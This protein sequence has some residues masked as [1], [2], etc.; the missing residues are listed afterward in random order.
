MIASNGWSSATP[1]LTGEL[2]RDALRTCMQSLKEGLPAKGVE[3]TLVLLPPVVQ[4]R[5]VNL[6]RMQDDELSRVLAR[7]VDRFMVSAGDS[8]IGYRRIGKGTRARDPVLLASASRAVV[9]VVSLALEAI[10]CTIAAVVPAHP[11]WIAS[12]RTGKTARVV[13]THDRFVEILESE[14]K[15]LT[16]VRRTPRTTEPATISGDDRFAAALLPAAGIELELVPN[17]VHQSRRLWSRRTQARL[18]AASIIVLLLSAGLWKLD[19]GREIRSVQRARAGRR[20]LVQQAIAIREEYQLG[21]KRLALIR[22][23][24]QSQ[25]EWTAVLANV[26]SRLPEEAYLTSFRARGDSL[27]LE[28]VAEQAATVFEALSHSPGVRSVRANSPIRQTLAGGIAG[29]ERFSLTAVLGAVD[30]AR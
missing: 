6:P 11:A 9:E 22:D 12:E 14:G 7:D 17:P 5:R 19:L 27:V 24:S 23:A 13:V 3:V 16:D 10:G 18:Y 30:S 8:V 29:D 21:L 20:E 1:D 28:G 25:W 2:N 26:T 4:M 15:R